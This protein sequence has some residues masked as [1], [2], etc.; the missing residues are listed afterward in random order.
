MKMETTEPNWQEVVALYTSA[1]RFTCSVAVFRCFPSRPE[2]SNYGSCVLSCFSFSRCSKRVLNGFVKL[3]SEQWDFHFCWTAYEEIKINLIEL[4][5]LA[6]DWVLLMLEDL[7]WFSGLNSTDQREWRSELGEKK[8]YYDIV[9]FKV[10]FAKIILGKHNIPSRNWF[11]FSCFR[12]YCVKTV[13][14]SEKLLPAAG[15]A[16]YRHH[17]WY[18]FRGEIEQTLSSKRKASSAACER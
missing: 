16:F 3:I 11:G 9:K 4:S 18:R 2:C 15:G 14:I 17:C 7:F 8:P 5:T 6:T 10:H 12:D 1:V 13:E